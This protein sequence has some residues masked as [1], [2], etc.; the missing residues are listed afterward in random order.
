MIFFEFFL[1]IHEIDIYSFEQHYINGNGI[2]KP[3]HTHFPYKWDEFSFAHSISCGCSCLHCSLCKYKKHTAEISIELTEG[4]WLPK[5]AAAAAASSCAI[6][7]QIIGEWNA[8]ERS[9]KILLTYVFAY[10]LSFE[11]VD[12]EEKVSKN[13]QNIC[14]HPEMTLNSPNF[15][16]T[17][18]RH[19][20]IL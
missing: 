10:K 9:R 17:L 14:I 18:R 12:V 20:E 3:G 6:I 4:F 1:S 15:L 13:H 19:L 8:D 16:C 7:Y 5:H 2:K 11:N